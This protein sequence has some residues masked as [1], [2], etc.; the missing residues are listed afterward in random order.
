MSNT[1]IPASDTY[2]PEDGREVI[3]QVMLRALASEAM[4]QGPLRVVETAPGSFDVMLRL[5]GTYSRREAAEA[6]ARF[7]LGALRDHAFPTV[8]P[9]DVERTPESG[10]GDL[11]IAMGEQTTGDGT[12]L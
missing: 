5:D 11:L 4:R 6:S 8:V 2:P 3:L 1:A 9:V 10:L 12:D 7:L